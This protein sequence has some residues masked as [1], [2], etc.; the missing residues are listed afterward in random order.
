MFMRSPSYNEP[1]Y[2]EPSYDEPVYN[3]PSYEE[4]SY[5][6]PAYEEPSYDGGSSSNSATGQAI[7][8]YALQFLGNP[9]VSGRKQSDQRN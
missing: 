4:P 8:D 1:V 7:V 3:E 2:E 9:Y 5:D 6:E